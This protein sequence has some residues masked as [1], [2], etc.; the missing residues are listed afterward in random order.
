LRKIDFQSFK[1]LAVLKRGED[2]RRFNV[3]FSERS[4]GYNLEGGEALKKC[5]LDV[6]RSIPELKFGSHDG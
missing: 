6:E 1:F 3:T 4:A 2:N 5:G